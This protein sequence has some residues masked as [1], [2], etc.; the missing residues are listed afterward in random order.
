MN[1]NTVKIRF[2]ASS[3]NMKTG[4]ISQTYSSCNTCPERCPFK[5]AGCYAKQGPVALVWKKTAECGINPQ[6][7]KATIQ[8]AKNVTEVIRHN[9]AGDIAIEGTNEINDQLLDTLC[10]AYQGHKAYTYTHTEINDHN[11]AAVIRAAE[12]GFVI[13]FSTEN[14]QDAKKAVNAGCNAVIACNT[15][16]KNVVKKEGLTIVRCPATYKEDITCSNCGMCYQKNRK[17]VVAFPVHG[18][19]KKKAI[20]AGFLSDL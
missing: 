20:K 5:N 9:V 14:L 3:K 2:V 13:N 7:L 15:I 11:V 4:A 8:A 1:E 18:G 17:A 10:D 12:K 19:G 6:D 16:S